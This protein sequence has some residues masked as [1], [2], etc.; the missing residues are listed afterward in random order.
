MS[1]HQKGTYLFTSLG[2]LFFAVMLGVATLLTAGVCALLEWAA[3]L[4]GWSTR[5]ELLIPRA[6]GWFTAAIALVPLGILA[7]W[8]LPAGTAAVSLYTV[9]LLMS[10]ALALAC[11]LRFSRAS[12]RSRGVQV[13]SVLLLILNGVQLAA[14]TGLWR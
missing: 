10:V 13:G 5:G 11:L 8:I 7:V 12:E 9:L 14:S 2:F 6:L 1:R 3:V 4:Q